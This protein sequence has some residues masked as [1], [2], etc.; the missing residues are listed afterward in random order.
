MIYLNSHDSIFDKIHSIAPVLKSL[1][2]KKIIV[3]YDNSVDNMQTTTFFE[4][5]L[6]LHNILLLDSLLITQYTDLHN[7]AA[8]LESF[9]SICSAFVVLS[10]KTEILDKMLDAA[11]AVGMLEEAFS[12]VIFSDYNDDYSPL[13]SLKRIIMFVNPRRHQWQPRDLVNDAVFL[14]TKG[15]DNIAKSEEKQ[16]CSCRC[17]CQPFTNQLYR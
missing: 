6:A 12:W 4:R 17:E 5:S 15:L 11:Y 7:L 14:A 2:F 9:R 8:K 1:Y 16:Q 13:F 10:S 3:I